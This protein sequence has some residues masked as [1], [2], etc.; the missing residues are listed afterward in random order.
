MP[1]PFD[2]G[3]IVALGWRQGA[4]LGETLSLRAAE[5]APAAAPKCP[6]DSLIVTSH[7]CDITNPSL[8]KEPV[9]EILRGREAAT[10]ETTRVLI[11]GRNPRQLEFDAVA[12]DRSLTICCAVHERWFVP[13]ELLLRE[14]PAWFV[15]DKQ[16][17]LIAEWLAKRYIRSAFPAA[18]DLRW[19]AKQ[20]DW[21]K[22]LRQNS[23][24]IQ[25]VYLRLS[26][27]DELPRERAYRV[28]LLLA[29]PRTIE[30]GPAWRDTKE[31]LAESIELFWTDAHPMIE[32]EEVDVLGVDEITLAD[33]EFF[34]RFDADWVSFA[35]E[36]PGTNVASDLSSRA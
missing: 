28:Y 32:F 8:D 13:R 36:T 9:V 4:V 29:V 6:S 18:F 3:R 14:E 10:T 5:Y 31:R 34:Q 16:R 27:L 19:R 12:D 25:A 2:S 23:K 22:I 26:T 24:W 21:L 1:E 30:D 17:R 35:D 11:G 20:R 33:I 7:D 15:P